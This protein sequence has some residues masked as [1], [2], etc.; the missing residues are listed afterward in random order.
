MEAS[1]KYCRNREGT[2][3]IREK[4]SKD[5]W[6]S[7]IR[8]F[9]R[10]LVK[11]AS[12]G[13]PSTVYIHSHSLVT[14][15]RVLP[16]RRNV[17]HPNPLVAHRDAPARSPDVG[18][19]LLAVGPGCAQKRAKVPAPA[20]RPATPPASTPGRERGRGGLRRSVGIRRTRRRGAWRT[21]ALI[22]LAP[23]PRSSSKCTGRSIS[24]P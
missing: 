8:I 12:R 15:R 21:L 2:F 19:L 18:E 10:V 11:N 23:S 13:L 3:S 20:P 22:R 17:R 16:R 5:P 4:F 7:G 6:I 9:T 14:S 24:C 1:Q